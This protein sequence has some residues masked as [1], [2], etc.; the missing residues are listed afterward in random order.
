[1][2]FKKFFCK[3]QLY[4]NFLKY[5]NLGIFQAHYSNIL[6]KSDYEKD[7]YTIFP[8]FSNHFK[9]SLIAVSSGF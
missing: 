6:V 3:Y 7:T 8:L 2:A 4:F 5:L 9:A 1:M